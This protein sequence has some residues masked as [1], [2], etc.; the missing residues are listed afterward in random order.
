MG[1]VSLDN[2]L[3]KPF[4]P[5]KNPENEIM[6]GIAINYK[7]NIPLSYGEGVGI[8]GDQLRCQIVWSSQVNSK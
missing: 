2:P 1:Y 4:Q 5:H 8:Y 6:K 3:T 7:R